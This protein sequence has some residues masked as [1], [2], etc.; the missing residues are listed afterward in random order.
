MNTVQ[1]YKLGDRS[2]WFDLSSTG[3]YSTQATVVVAQSGY[4]QL[5]VS[6]NRPFWLVECES[7]TI[8][9]TS[10]SCPFWHDVSVTGRLVVFSVLRIRYSEIRNN[11]DKCRNE[12]TIRVIGTIGTPGMESTFLFKG[13]I[14][15]EQL[16]NK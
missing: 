11:I 16:D 15:V 14:L 12:S 7:V 3:V 1:F 8:N 2:I 9:C 4:L 10:R 5:P 13:Q 6:D